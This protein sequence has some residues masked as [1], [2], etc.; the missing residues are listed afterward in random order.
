MIKAWFNQH[1]FVFFLVIKRIIVAPVTSLLSILVMGIAFSLPA[2]IYVLVENL[3]SISSQTTTTPQMSLFL[4]QEA[5]QRDIGEI[6]RLLEENEQVIRFQFV[7]KDQ[8]LLQLQQNSGLNNV[9]RSLG[10]NPLPDAFIVDTLDV[11]AESLDQ[12]RTVMQAWPSVEYVQFDSAWAKRLEAIL[13][14]GQAIALML[15]TLLSVAIIA[16]M[17]NTIR[18][19]ILTKQDEIEVSKLIGATDGFIRRPFLYF[20][21]IQGLAG[22]IAALVIIALALQTMNT[23]LSVLAELYSIDLHLK[24]LSTTDS[25]SLLL[26]AT[27]LGWLGARLSV[28]SHLWK[29]EPK[30]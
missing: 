28:A 7:S 12:L 27:W 4:Q 30:Y 15:F 24:H 3:Q 29:I 25:I 20:G 11:N 19:Q 6:K 16:V 23:D 5:V 1:V 26:F 17:F 22:G 18:L 14:F 2:G 21:A 13:N 8:A 10:Y 9:M